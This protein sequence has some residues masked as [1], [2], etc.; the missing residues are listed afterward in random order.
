M[1]TRISPVVSAILFVFGWL[2]PV[3]GHDH[4][5]AEK[6]TYAVTQEPVVIGQWEWRYRLVSGWGK[7][8]AAQLELGHCHAMVEDQR[9]LIYMANVH[10]ENAIVVLD[11]AGNLVDTWGDFTPWAHGLTIATEG[12]QEVLFITENNRNGKVWKTTLTGEVL[13]EIGCPMESGLY[14]S[15]EKFR[16]SK[17]MVLPDGDLLVLD[18]YGKDYV[19]RFDAEGNFLSAFGGDLGKGEA[20]IEHWGPHGS[21]IDYTDPAHPELILALS[22]QQQ[23]KR[24]TMQGDWLQTVALPGSNPRDIVFH[25]DHIVI[26]NLGDDWPADTNAAGYISVLNRDFKVVAN[27]GGGP[28]VYRDGVLQPMGHDSHLFLHPHGIHFDKDGNLYVAQYDSN[29]TFPL[30]FERIP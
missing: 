26:P 13:M 4:P 28:P 11:H 21:G 16:P 10:P 14:E 8:A 9:G 12:D 5:H 7:A 22:D 25:R 20:R 1:K 23:I 3:W 24:L 2:P 17:I 30:K 6:G 18:G 15:P 19:L 27:L 29:Q